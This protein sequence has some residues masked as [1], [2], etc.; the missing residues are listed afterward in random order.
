MTSPLHSADPPRRDRL[1]RFFLCVHLVV[2]AFI[3]L[4]WTI[5]A[6]G[7]LLAY[8]VFLPAVVLHWKLNHDACVLN[9]I[10]NWL[11]F[12]RWRAPDR[13]A[14]EGAWLRNLIGG[15]TGVRL[16]QGQTDLLTYGAMAVFWF[17]ALAHF[18]RMT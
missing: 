16:T 1:G 14:E 18:L 9:N 10:E 4:G 2:L 17:L 7:V 15:A 11:R 8:L 12:R 6:R 5:P 13:N 3:L